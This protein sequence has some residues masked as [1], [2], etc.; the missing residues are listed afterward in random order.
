MKYIVNGT[1]IR[2]NKGIRLGEQRLEKFNFNDEVIHEYGNYNIYEINITTDNTLIE[3][4]ML[5]SS[6]KLSI[7]EYDT[8]WGDGVVD[9]NISHTYNIG[10]YIIKTKYKVKDYVTKIK[11]IMYNLTNYNSVFNG[12]LLSD[13]PSIS[14]VATLLTSTFGGCINLTISPMLPNSVTGMRSTFLGCTN[15]TTIRNLPNN[16]SSLIDTFKN[17]TSLVDAPI[18]PDSITALNGT[19]YGCEKLKNVYNF[20]KNL[21]YMSNAFNGC[22]SLI[23]IPKI[24]DTVTQMVATFNNCTSMINIPILPNSIASLNGTFSGCTNLTGTLKILSTTLTLTNITECILNTQISEIQIPSN[25]VLAQS[26]DL[27]IQT[28]CGKADVTITRV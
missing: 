27:E 1:D 18:L 5:N 4:Y 23:E 20:P 19:F 12:Y 7:S 16:I 8:N 28:T 3:L 13:F 17:C 26:T 14:K 6:N 21:S 22:T 2:E 9:K 10:T 15:L 25:S 24:P 11:N